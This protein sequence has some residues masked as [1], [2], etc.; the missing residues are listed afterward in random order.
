MAPLAEV[1]GL[2]EKLRTLTRDGGS[3]EAA[4][5]KL[6][7][8]DDIRQAAGPRWPRMRARVREV[9]ENILSRHAGEGDIVVPAGDGFLVIF[10]EDIDTHERCK[11]MRDA[12]LS[13]YLGEDALKTLQPAVQRRVVTTESLHALLRHHEPQPR[14]GTL[15]ASIAAAPVFAISDKRIGLSLWGPMI[16][17]PRGRR[18]GY[19]P[20]FVL[21]GVRREQMDVLELD[22]AVL[23]AALHSAMQARQAKRSLAVALTVHATTLQ[24]RRARD[25]YVAR[26]ESYDSELRRRLV[27]MVAEIEKGTP[28]IS[29]AEWS[30]AL[31][32]HLA[33]VW[34]DFHHTDH[35]IA[36]LR[37][38]GALAAGFHLPG[39]ATSGNPRAQR[40]LEHAAFW[41]RT[42]HSQGLRF[43]INGFHDIG[44]CAE[45]APFG[46]DFASG[47]A[48]WPLRTDHTEPVH[49]PMHGAED[50]PYIVQA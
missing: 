44:F 35:A 10:A 50:T 15:P 9:S 7:G 13:F 41:G 16:D 31:R 46:V 36:G 29:I 22:L 48:V 5:I 47:D 2:A 4:Q 23:D 42:L 26:L 17:E 37:G 39:Y 1:E 40:M 34:L 45:A 27:V 43:F 11:R 18:I 19:D 32:T 33:H 6:I 21:D 38:A 24:H 12:L 49:R 25:A 20:D 8:L 3:F 30:A 14:A 28:F